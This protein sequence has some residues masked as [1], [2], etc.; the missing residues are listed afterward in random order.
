MEVT[1]LWYAIMA[2]P[3]E[4]DIPLTLVVYSDSQYVVKAFT[5]GWLK[6][7]LGNN[8]NNGLCKNKTLWA[9]I[10]ANLERRKDFMDFEIYHIRSHQVE[11]EKN[12]VAKAYLMQD[13]HIIGNM[14]ADR[15]ADYKRHI[16][17]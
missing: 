4:S 9:A 5:E 2:M 14:M 6:K 17:K 11:K 15:L 16:N 10:W 13:P 1:A 12:P 8:W 3:V 7:W